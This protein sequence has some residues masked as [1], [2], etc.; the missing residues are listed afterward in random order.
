MIQGVDVS[1]NNNNG[2]GNVEFDAVKAAGKQFAMIRVGY[3]T[4][5][6]GSFSGY[7]SKAFAPQVQNAAQAGLDTGAYWF[8]GAST[9]A[10]ARTEARACLEAIQDFQFTYPIAYDQEYTSITAPLSRRL[11]TDICLAFLQEVQDAG[12]YAMIYASKSW[13]ENELYDAELRPYDHWLAQ[14]AAA[15]TY[16]GSF[17]MWQYSGSGSIAG[18]TG[19]IDLDVAYKDYPAIIRAAGLNHLGDGGGT[20]YQALYEAERAKNQA[21]IAGMQALIDQYGGGAGQLNAQ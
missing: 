2:T 8:S 13:F 7:V 18:V 5:Y 11:R 10:E 6:G 4:R 9:V 16:T 20:D 1:S 15:P 21:L 17:G 19:P 14:Y 12:Y 3:G